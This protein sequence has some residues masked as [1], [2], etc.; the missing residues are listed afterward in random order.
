MEGNGVR[1]VK[2]GFISSSGLLPFGDVNTMSSADRLGVSKATSSRELKK[3]LRSG[4]RSDFT[5]GES[6]WLTSFSGATFD[7][8]EEDAAP[9]PESCC[10]EEYVGGVKAPGAQLRVLAVDERGLVSLP[11]AVS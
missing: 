10:L 2:D 7:A 6:I 9:V 1:G 11:I 3:A 5:E 4:G 8:G